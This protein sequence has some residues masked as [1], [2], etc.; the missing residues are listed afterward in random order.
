M[1]DHAFKLAVCQIRTEL[2]KAVTMEKARCMVREAA[3]NGANVVVLPEMYN[4]PYS[5]EYFKPFADA[6][7]GESLEQMSA[8]A[9]DNGVILVG[10][11]I[12]EKDGDKLSNSEIMLFS[13]GVA[14]IMSILS[15]RVWHRAVSGDTSVFTRAL[16]NPSFSSS[17]KKREQLACPSTSI[18]R[19]LLFFASS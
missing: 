16:S 4:C 11:T 17:V 15:Y 3:E 12:P 6:E 8:W 2:D 19:T 13:F 10:G 5:K 1:S 9:R 14:V 7:N 18:I